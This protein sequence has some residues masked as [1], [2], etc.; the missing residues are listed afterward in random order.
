MMYGAATLLAFGGL[1]IAFG[2]NWEA[3]IA[4]VVV[5][6]TISYIINISG[7]WRSAR[8]TGYSRR[9]SRRPSVN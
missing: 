8:M 1:V 2:Q 7:L 6:G 9:P 5:I 3:G 4:L